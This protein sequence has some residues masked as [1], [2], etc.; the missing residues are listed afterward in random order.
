MNKNW[1]EWMNVKMDDETQPTE[2]WSEKGNC[3]GDKILHIV[4][5][6]L[7]CVFMLTQIHI[8]YIND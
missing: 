7:N 1:K 8:Q 3:G 2:K 5:N 6:Q 4:I